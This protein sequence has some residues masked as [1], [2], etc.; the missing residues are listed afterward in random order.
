MTSL[1]F[2]LQNYWSC[3]Y[4]TLMRCK[5]SWKLI[6]RRILVP[7]GFLVLQF[8]VFMW[9]NHIPKSTSF[10]GSYLFLPRESNP[11]CGWSR[12]CLCKSNPHTGWVFDLILSTLSMEVTVALP[13]RRYFETLFE[14]SVLRFCLNFYEYEMLIEKEV[15]LFFPSF[16]QPSTACFGIVLHSSRIK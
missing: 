2:K 9:R 6:F 5:S 1:K 7:N 14:R 16:K 10:S 15:C 4:F 8:L 13:Y 12:A 11:G 3:K